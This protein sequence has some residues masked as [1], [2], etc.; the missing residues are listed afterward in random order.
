MSTK[1]YQTYVDELAFGTRLF[2]LVCTNGTGALPREPHGRD[3]RDVHLVQL[4]VEVKTT[5]WFNS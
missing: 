5:D 4:L 3:G 2:T 1:N